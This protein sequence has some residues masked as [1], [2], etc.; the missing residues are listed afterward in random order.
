MDVSHALC[1]V[2]AGKELEIAVAALLTATDYPEISRWIQF[3]RGLMLFL[4]V[5]G[6]AASGTVYVYDRCDGIWYWVDFQDRNYGGYSLAEL[7]VLLDRCYFLQ[8][9]ENPRCLRRSE[10]F[11]TPG[12]APQ[13]VAGRC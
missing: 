5:P 6:D 12:Q 4:L 1:P 2:D 9:V 11:V 3:P 10:W 8:L 13:A 7:D